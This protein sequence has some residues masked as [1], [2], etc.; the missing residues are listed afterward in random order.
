MSVPDDL[1]GR[2]NMIVIHL[3][4][5]FTATKELDEGNAQAL[6][7]HVFESFIREMEAMVRDFGVEGA[8]AQDEVRHIVSLCSKQIMVYDN[9]I[10]SGD[11]KVL[12]AEILT[13]FQQVQENT[14]VNADA[15]AGY[16]LNSVARVQGQPPAAIL[17][18]HIEFPV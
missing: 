3:L 5:L 15:L 6:R 10:A 11:M 7:Q 2:Y 13:V 14:Q 16:I 9:A 17:N 18:G 12:S 1:S 4:I 8:R